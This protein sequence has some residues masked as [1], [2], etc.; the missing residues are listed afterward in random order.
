MRELAFSS[1]PMDTTLPRKPSS[2]SAPT[3]PTSRSAFRPTGTGQ[4]SAWLIDASFAN[5]HPGEVVGLL[6]YSGVGK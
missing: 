2:R 3:L 1:S 6:G 5:H 4:A